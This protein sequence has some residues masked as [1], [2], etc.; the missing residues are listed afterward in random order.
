MMTAAIYVVSVVNYESSKESSKGTSFC[1]NLFTHS[2]NRDLLSA[3]YVSGT[4]VG[5][6]D[7]E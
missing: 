2:V 6:R 1:T 7:K 5:I 4:I 3:Y